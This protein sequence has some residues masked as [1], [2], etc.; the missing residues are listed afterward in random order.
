MN[1]K[2]G[3]QKRERYDSCVQILVI[4]A[5]ANHNSM[6]KATVMFENIE[7]IKRKDGT[8]TR[9]NTLT[10]KL[11][12]TSTTSIWNKIF[13]GMAQKYDL[14]RIKQIYIL[15]DGAS[16]IK[17]GVLDMDLPNTKVTFAL[18]R[19]HTMQ[20]I[21]RITKNEVYLGRNAT[22]KYVAILL[23]FKTNQ[24]V[25]I[26][27]GRTKDSL[28]SYFQKIPIETLNK[29]QYLSF[30][31]YEGYRFLQ[32][33]YLKQSRLCVDSFHV[34]QTINTMFSS[35]RKAITKHFEEGS[36]EYYLLKKKRYIL[37]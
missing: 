5:Y 31:M 4:Q 13:D 32:R 16:W 14:N 12:F 7:A 2:L 17:H 26:I 34:I 24:I 27:Y 10:N 3:I 6:M 35:Q 23:D 37:L 20:A 9:R 25:D 28:H 21:Q 19:F 1:R 29:V 36:I 18:D 22:K 30:D 15:G 11:I 8:N 33:S